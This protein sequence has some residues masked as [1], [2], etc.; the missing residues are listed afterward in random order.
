MEVIINV[1]LLIMLLFFVYKIIKNSYIEFEENEC[2]QESVNIKNAYF[3]LDCEC[4]QK[5]NKHCHTCSSK[6]LYPLGKWLSNNNIELPEE[7][8]PGE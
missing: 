6:S 4:I 5:D 8:Y 2:H 1:F 7:Y 3:C